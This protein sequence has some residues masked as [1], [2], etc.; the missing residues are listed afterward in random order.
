MPMLQK[1]QQKDFVSKLYLKQQ[2]FLHQTIII[3]IVFLEGETQTV[4]LQALMV[5]MGGTANS[6]SHGLIAVLQSCDRQR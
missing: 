5:R 3:I 2:K 6:L 4:K 1:S